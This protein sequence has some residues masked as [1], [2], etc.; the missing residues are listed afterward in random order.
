MKKW[1]KSKITYETKETRDVQIL[2]ASHMNL[3]LA[4]TLGL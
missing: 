3:I 1:Q 2:S 4:A